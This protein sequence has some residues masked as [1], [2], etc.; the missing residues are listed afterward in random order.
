MLFIFFN[1]SS[2]EY[3]FGAILLMGFVENSTAFFGHK[4]SRKKRRIDNNNNNN[5]VR[6]SSAMADSCGKFNCRL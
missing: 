5:A 1:K 3:E 2:S 4:Q 6:T